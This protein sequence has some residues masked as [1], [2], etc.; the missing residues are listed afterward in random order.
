MNKSVSFHE[1]LRKKHLATLWTCFINMFLGGW[2]L[3]GHAVFGYKSDEMIYSDCI[4]GIIAMLFSFFSL[5]Y[6]RTW[7]PWMVCLVGVWLQ[8]APLIFWAPD[9]SAYVNDTLIGVFLILFSLLI[10]GVPGK[11]ST[12]GPEIPPGWSYNPSSWLQRIPIIFLGSLGW[13]IARYLAAYQLGYIDTMWDP[14]FGEGTIHVITSNI[15]KAFPIPDAGLGAL[16]Y[17]FEALMG[18]KG[19]TRRWYTMPWIVVGFGILV[20]PLG[21]VSII[22]IILQPLVVGSFCT[23]CL[24]TALAMLIMISLT[25][26]EVVAVLQYLS[27]VRKSKRSF[28]KIFFQGGAEPLAR[29]DERTPLFTD[30]SSKIFSSMTWGI[31]IPW[32]LLFTA[33]LGGLL[34]AAPSLFK[35]TGKLADLDPIL[36]ALI[37]TA[38][39]IAMA[40][41]IRSV[42]YVN[43]LFAISILLSSLV[44]GEKTLPVLFF[45][46]IV[47]GLLLILTFRKGRIL[48]KYG[49][50]QRF[51]H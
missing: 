48:E 4:S 21:L 20:V 41:V 16:A 28:W 50:W 2:L 12:T 8:F 32:N 3:T 36:G 29:Y 45:H 9:P 17:T 10:P 19:D 33:V 30:K 7:A 47:S 24:C 35:I 38:S 1:A 18:C 43:L 6:R 51:I 23:L 44:F 42:R 49:A 46:I 22:L 26:D 25:V 13:F 39:I 34:I 40:E 31:T 27:R 37:V 14:F 11:L 15:S 5:S